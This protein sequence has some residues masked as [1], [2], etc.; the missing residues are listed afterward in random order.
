MFEERIIY[1]L[2]IVIGLPVLVVAVARGAPVD[3]GPSLAGLIGAAGCIGLWRS[4][5]RVP[6]VPRARSRRRGG[7]ATGR[8]R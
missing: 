7:P 8:P 6:V 2:A 4:R 3:P 5:R 1:V